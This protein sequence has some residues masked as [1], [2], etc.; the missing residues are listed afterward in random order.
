MDELSE[1]MKDVIEQQIIPELKA[2]TIIAHRISNQENLS[3]TLVFDREC[4]EPAF[5][6]KAMG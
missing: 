2:N 1:K 5:F 4:Y 6:Q 3:F